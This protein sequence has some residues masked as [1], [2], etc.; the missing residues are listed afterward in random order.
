MEN[1]ELV[2]QDVKVPFS[3]ILQEKRRRFDSLVVI[4]CGGEATRAIAGCG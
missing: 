2:K 1:V 3:G 4:G